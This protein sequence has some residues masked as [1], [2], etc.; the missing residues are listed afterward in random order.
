MCVCVY[1]HA[2]TKG[3]ELI[4]EMYR[5]R[6][7][8]CTGSLINAEIYGCSSTSTAAGGTV[9]VVGDEEGTGDAMMIYGDWGT[10]LA[11]TKKKK[12]KYFE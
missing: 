12:R 1:L 4:L 7:L 5:S 9:A 10:V 3:F 2:G 6:L 11:V 8:C